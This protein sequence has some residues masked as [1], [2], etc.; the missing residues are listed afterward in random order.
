MKRRGASLVGTK[1]WSLQGMEL[2]W[3]GGTLQAGCFR[4]E[5]ETGE[6]IME[7]R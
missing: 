4:D 2:R 5:D 6:I 3:V 7:D 1:S